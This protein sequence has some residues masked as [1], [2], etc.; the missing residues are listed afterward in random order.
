MKFTVFALLAASF[1][2]V[3]AVDCFCISTDDNPA[4]NLFPHRTFNLGGLCEERGGK[5]DLEARVCKLLPR[6]GTF[7]DDV[8]RIVTPNRAMVANCVASTF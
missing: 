5:L 3:Y 1:S 4:N 7:T 2:T 8:C 6:N